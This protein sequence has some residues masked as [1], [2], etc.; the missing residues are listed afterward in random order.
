VRRHLT[1]ARL[2]R[3]GAP[4][5]WLVASMPGAAAVGEA[6]GLTVIDVPIAEVID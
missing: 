6:W 4:S 2:G 3:R 1:T 5:D